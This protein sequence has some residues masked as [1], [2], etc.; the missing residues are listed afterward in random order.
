[1]NHEQQP[2]P[3]DAVDAAAI[4][5]TSTPAPSPW[6]PNEQVDDVDT[7]DLRPGRPPEVQKLAE[8]PQIWVGSWLDYNNGILHGRWIDAARDETDV[9]T[10]I[11][12]M[13]AASPTAKKY[14]ETAEDWGIFDTDN[15]GK[16]RIGESETVERVT[17]LARGIAEHGPAFA[18]W[19]ELADD[20]GQLE[21]FSDSYIG[22]Y[23]SLEAYVEEMADDAGYNRLLDETIPASIRGYVRLDTAALAHDMWID[24][25]IFKAHRPEGGVWLFHAN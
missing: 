17:K 15:F 3:A 14:G 16:L 2:N 7:V 6:D 18:A 19:A 25:A 12:A 13:L 21:D 22:E 24:G 1:M 11:E 5:S 4:D 9:W 20:H 10:D 23:D 8:P